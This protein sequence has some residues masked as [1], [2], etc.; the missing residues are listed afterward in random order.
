G[1]KNDPSDSDVTEIAYDNRGSFVTAVT[2]PLNLSRHFRRDEGTG[3]LSQDIANDGIVTNLAYNT[4]GMVTRTERAGL[5]TERQYNALDQV[6]A[7]SDAAGRGISLRYDSA[8]RPVHMEDAQGYFSELSLDTEGRIKVSGL[9]EPAGEQAPGKLVRATYR[10]YD[11]NN[12]LS[13]Q[14][15]P[16][17]RLDTYAY[18]AQGRLARHVDGDDVL[19]LSAENKNNTARANIDLAA[20]GMLRV[21][22][23]LAPSA[24]DAAPGKIQPNI[25]R[26]DFGRVLKMHLADYGNKTAS[27]DIRDRMIRLDQADGSSIAFR[28]D[29]AGR[30]IQKTTTTAGTAKV[31]TVS[32]RYQG[33]RLIDV[34]DPVQTTA[35][36]YDAAGRIAQTRITI[37]GQSYTLATTYDPRTGEP[38][39][40]RLADGQV[41]Q[42]ERDKA[43]QVARSISLQG[44]RSAGIA[45]QIEKLPSWL[46]WAK[47]ILPKQTVVAEIGFNP[48]NGLTGYTQGNGIKTAKG[49]DIAGRLTSMK[50]G[51]GRNSI[52]SWRYDYGVGPRIRALQAAADTQTN[53]SGNIVKA[54]YDYSGF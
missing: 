1:P 18:D 20:D 34:T 25:L 6:S 17:G 50:I 48:Y 8:G 26:D 38:S 43:T 44:E 19:H 45:G 5:I 41:M 2:Y 14:L 52:A 24:S 10:S 15:Q 32:L 11:E 31:S 13:R 36:A 22:F 16:D 21:N 40:Q 49:F 4:L 23:Q 35:Y 7:L 47:A 53:A 3:R 33:N 54:S 42:I 27:Y 12:R 30:M 51:D 29:L 37:D 28:Y 39:T 46:Q 9:Y